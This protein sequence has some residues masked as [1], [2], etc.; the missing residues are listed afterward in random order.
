VRDP[1]LVRVEWVELQGARPREAGANA[2]LGPHGAVVRV[3][4]ARLTLDDGTSGFGLA[5][6]T[7]E[8]AEGLVG[9]RLSALFSTSAGATTR[10]LSIDIP[11]W[12]LVSRREGVPV[13]AMA[14]RMAGRSTNRAP[15]PRCYDT[16]LYFDDLHLEDD[17][18]AAAL[19]TGEALQGRA[20][21]HRHF[22][23]KVGRGARHMA[24]DAGT[25]R[26]IAVV[27]A[28]RQAVGPDAELMIDA[29]NG[30]NLNLTKQVLSALA[31]CRIYWVEE[32][33]H[34]DPVLYSDL[35]DWLGTQGLR[36]LIADGE[37]W[38]PPSLVEWAERGLIDV[39]Q[40]DILAYG[41]TRWLATGRRLDR[42]AIGSAPHHYGLHLGN[43]VAAHLAGAVDHLAFV[44]WD[45]A[46]TPGID[47]AGYGVE[48][49][50]VRVPDAP[51]FGLDLDGAT[52]T[53]AV[54]DRGFAVD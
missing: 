17:G 11:L 29:N 37:G 28:I 50:T 27:R 36:T 34:E 5:R 52:F 46:S 43:F 53:A 14:A 12:D 44:E 30:Y 1:L 38:A 3:P 6:P 13:Y 47:D 20:R 22:K 31:D 41:L 42:R 23:I 48:N 10:G 25:R 18:E 4:L 15:R 32:A 24:L 33:F 21:G 39:V 2:R 49:G 16:T 40:F 19:I 26:D 54:R 35:R 8:D 9:T 45:E 51:G 7:R